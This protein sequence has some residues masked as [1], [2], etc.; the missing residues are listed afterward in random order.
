MLF[1]FNI[2]GM[3][4]NKENETLGNDGGDLNMDFEVPVCN[5]HTT[6]LNKTC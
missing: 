6:E 5:N 1:S 4:K 3:R 2:H